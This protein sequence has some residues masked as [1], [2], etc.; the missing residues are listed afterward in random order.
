M[1]L[2]SSEEE[3]IFFDDS[4]SARSDAGGN[5]RTPAAGSR[6]DGGENGAAGPIPSTPAE[7]RADE[8]PSSMSMTGPS[9][10]TATKGETTTNETNAGGFPPTYSTATAEA[11]G[12]TMVTHRIVNTK[13]G[14]KAVLTSADGTEYW[15]SPFITKQLQEGKVSLPAKV[16]SFE[17]AKYGKIGYKLIPA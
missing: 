7:T 11:N 14:P 17:S 1:T 13:F 2:E 10:K 16:V 9:G 5:G 6:N 8:T 4:Q 12:D 15:G 3:G